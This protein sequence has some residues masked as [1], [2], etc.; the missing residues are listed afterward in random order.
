MF[1]AVRATLVAVLLST[2]AVAAAVQETSRPPME[3]A[4]K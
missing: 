2:A 4:A 3:L 1:R